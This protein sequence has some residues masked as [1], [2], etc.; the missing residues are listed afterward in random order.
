MKKATESKPVKN[1]IKKIPA[2]NKEV[3][4]ASNKII[5]KYKSAIKKLAKR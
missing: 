5:T 4:V 3:K 1:N 2:T